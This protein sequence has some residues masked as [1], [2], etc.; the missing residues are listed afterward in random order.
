MWIRNVKKSI[1]FSKQI[2]KTQVI[3]VEFWLCSAFELAVCRPVLG[4]FIY[5]LSSQSIESNTYHDAAISPINENRLK[6]NST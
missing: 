2:A 1:N 3:Q 5:L 6:T 4:L